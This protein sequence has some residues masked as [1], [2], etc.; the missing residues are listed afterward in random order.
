[1]NCRK[2]GAKQVTR[3]A[4]GVFVCQ[5]CGVQPGPL[6]LD[7]FG[8]ATRPAVEPATVTA[9]DYQIAPRQPRLQAAPNLGANN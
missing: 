5:H 7:R 2:C 3:R 1:M 4:A 6:H 8:N 9:T